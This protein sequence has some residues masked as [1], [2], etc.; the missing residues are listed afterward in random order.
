[1][2]C[3]ADPSPKLMQLG[4]TKT[5]RGFNQHHA[6][7]GDIDTD[8]EHS[9]ADQRIRFAAPEPFHDLLLFNDD[10]PEVRKRNGLV[11]QRMR[12][13]D[14]LW[15]FARA[16]LGSARVSRASF[17]V[18]PK[19]TFLAILVILCPDPRIILTLTSQT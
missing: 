4:Q 2:L 16:H 19:R 17:G 10:E 8:L 18:A 14:D 13:D 1:M 11:E 7:I 5:L 3:A 6:G 12:S 9:R 15:F